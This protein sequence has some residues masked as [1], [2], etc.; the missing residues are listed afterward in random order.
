M[1][2]LECNG[3]EI[4]AEQFATLDR[5]LDLV[6]V[7]NGLGY[8]FYTHKGKRFATRI[9]ERPSYLREGE[10]LWNAKQVNEFNRHYIDPKTKGES[11]S[12]QFNLRFRGFAI[13]AGDGSIQVMN[14]AD[15][16]TCEDSRILF[17]ERTADTE[18]ATIM[19]SVM[20]ENY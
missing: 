13:V 16:Y 11:L 15:W 4:N 7:L 14:S 20:K 19:G 10:V 8:E 9:P 3:K 1:Y 2:K 5:L 18:N 6:R 17:A 12:P